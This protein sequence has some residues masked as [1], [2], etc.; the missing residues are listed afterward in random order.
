MARYFF[1]ATHEDLVVTDFHGC[2]IGG[3][4]EVRPA[5]IEATRAIRAFL[6]AELAV[7][8]WNLEVRLGE[9]NRITTVRFEDVEASGAEAVEQEPTPLAA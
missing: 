6:G 4:D 8:D 5:M 1:D 2:E 7:K 9:D 3:K